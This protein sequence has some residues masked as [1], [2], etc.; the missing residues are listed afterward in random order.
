MKR[1][2]V[3]AGAIGL[4]GI[5]LYTTQRG[6]RYPRIT[7]EPRDVDSQLETPTAAF[8]LT[9][10]II[11]KDRTGSTNTTLKFRAYAPEPKLEIKVLASNNLKLNIQNISPEAKLNVLG[12]NI[13][14][15]DEHISGLSRELTIES[16]QA[17]TIQLDWRLDWEDGFD[18]ALLGDT[19]GGDELDWS[20]KRAHELGAKFLLH[21]GD[22]HYTEGEYDLAITAFNTAALPCYISIGNHDFNDNGLVYQ[23]FLDQIGPFNSWFAIAGTRFIN[24]DTALS[25]FPASAGHRGG[26][27]RQLANAQNNFTDQVIFTHRPIKDPRPNDDHHLTGI[28]EIEWV[29]KM[30]R[31]V[32]AKTYFN[33]HVHHSAELDTQ[34]LHQYTIGE[35]LAH[36]DLVLQ[37]QVAQL[38]IGRVQAGK[39]VSYQWQDLSM[40]W[41]AHTSPTHEVKLRVDKRT[42][43]LEWYKSLNT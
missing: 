22:F 11:V 27:M 40:P 38:L 37:K 28:G 33:G 35:G 23:Q 43:Q 41:S 31:A 2:S 21:L 29:G 36:E 7:F 42:K 18:F 10:L 13:K 20:I 24:L 34:G 14:L 4:G 9:D 17:Q 8:K 3:L 16:N 6:L 15:V 30:A 26:F 1:R 25:F 39:T 32:G 19:G 12:K 5:A